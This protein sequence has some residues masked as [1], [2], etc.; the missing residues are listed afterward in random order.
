MKSLRALGIGTI[1]LNVS[2][3]LAFVGLLSMPPREACAAP[4][5]PGP[6]DWPVIL[7]PSQST[8]APSPATLAEPAQHVTWGSDLAAA[9]L[10]AKAENKPVFVTLR[11]LPCKQC[12]VFDKDVLE[13]GADLDPLL[14]QFVTVR[15]IDAKPADLR[16]LPMATY[17]D[18]DLSWWGYFLSPQGRV[19]G[20]FGGRDEVS[21]ATRISKPAL[22][23][24]LKRVLAHHNDP[25]R[26][27]WDIDGPPPDMQAPL[28]TPGD[29]PGYA[30][31]SKKVKLDARTAAAGCV[32]CHQVSEILREPSIEAKTFDKNR[33]LQIWPL[34]ENVGIKVDRDNGLLV[35]EIV[36]N[37][38]AE[39]AGL[40]AGDTLAAAGTGANLRKLFGQAD[41]R[42]VLHRLPH[43]A[44]AVDL[45]YLRDGKAIATELTLADGW[46]KTVLDWR[47]SVSQGN[48]GAGPGFFPINAS[49]ADRKKLGVAD[50]EML[51]HAYVWDGPPK[52]A[53]LKQNDWII[54][55]D[56]QKPDLYGRPLMIWFRLRHEPG[57]DVALT[58]RRTGGPVEIR[59]KAE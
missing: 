10:L 58:V 32:H 43:D 52:S 28:Q 6:R 20:V 44:R 8:L 11:C 37:S 34:P 18:L 2:C 35:T 19:Y 12:A 3:L 40:K 39:K 13:G 56:G 26:A 36:K 46:R 45:Y 17:Q 42:G 5:A 48:I 30:G 14:K 9:L 50:G 51:V 16:I 54:A 4:S 1:T 24:T 55:I 47:K 57:D 23:A 31:W 22:I 15:L 7:G 49:P 25:R 33:D 29:L 41:F 21:D 27:G 53:G 38:P 59:F